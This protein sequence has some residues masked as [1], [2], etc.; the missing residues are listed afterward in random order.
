MKWDAG[1]NRRSGLKD[2]VELMFL[3]QYVHSFDDKSRL[4]VPAR[5]RELI[6]DGAFVV[7][8][9]DRNLMVLTPAAFEI[10]Y[11][12]IMAMNL[13]DPTARLLRRVILGNASQLDVDKSGRILIPQQLR[14]FAGL[15]GEAVLVGQGDY[16]EIWAPKLWQ[17][18][19]NQV[20]DAEANTQR[21]A[22]LDLKTR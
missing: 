2:E 12:R 21:F 19:V 14:E 22:A 9:L 20:Q 3:G 4:T 5:Y 8:G 13:T 10:I 7:Q 16:F 15:D 6:A 17:Q 18:Q 1:Q 11:Q